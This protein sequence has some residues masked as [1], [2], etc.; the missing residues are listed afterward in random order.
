MKQRQTQELVRV[1]MD[2]QQ[3]DGSFL[4]YSV[5][6]G[7]RFGSE[8]KAYTTTFTQALIVGALAKI[9]DRPLEQ[10]RKRAA[11]FLLAQR[12]PEW[13]FNYW[14]REAPETKSRPYPDDWDD[15]SSA[16]VALTLARP[17][18]VTGEV[19][20][21][22]V[23]LLT[24][25]E[26]AEG[27]PYRTWIVPPNA[28]EH[29]QDV[30]IA[31]NSNIAYMLQLHGVD[32]PNLEHLADTCIAE[33]R[34]SSP[35][36][37]S[38]YPI[39]YFLSRWYRGAYRGQLQERI[40][41]RQ[42]TG[43]WGNPLDTALAV[44]ALLNIGA[45]PAAV[46]GAVD[47]L[48]AQRPDD[49]APY[50]FCL[51][52]AIEGRPYVAGSRALTAAFCLEAI[53]KYDE[54]ARAD[55]AKTPAKAAKASGALDDRIHEQVV[56]QAMARFDQSER[57]IQSAARQMHDRLLGGTAASQIALLPYLFRQA[58][59]ENGRSI[60]DERVVALGV[61]S[62]YGWLAYTVYDDFLDEE[63]EPPLL[64]LANIALR[65]LVLALHREAAD[66]RGFGAVAWPALDR[67]EAA[68]AWE[69]TH[70][71]VRRQSDLVRVPPPEYAD[72][73]VLAERSMGHALGCLAITMELGHGM[74]SLE[75]RA[76]QA[77]FHHFLIARQL[78]DD[79]QD[80]K[81]DLQKGQINAVGAYLL[82]GMS[83]RG[84]SVRHLYAQLDQFFWEHAVGEI[85]EWIFGE[86]TQARAA[87]KGA[88]FIQKP[89]VLEALLAPLEEA[90]HKAQAQQQQMVEFLRT[91]Q[92]EK[93]A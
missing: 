39:E 70:C 41:A 14:A 30:D 7:T 58:L 43:R 88:A 89:E 31:V 24:N 79:A 23:A 10:V 37:P 15:T 22:I 32:L 12:G 44:S 84:P 69:V 90:A 25:T 51:D 77:F 87:L 64:P 3:A 91:Y 16:I 78:C 33:G 63:G 26:T 5:P 92:P 45:E 17:K 42:K 59:G 54:A 11:D 80:W 68:N 27:G 72:R 49:I 65:E 61:I 1:L 75:V 93:P 66:T 9:P 47:W 20:G 38:P 85:N 6:L 56:A 2:D 4:S 29:W 50:A 67:Q 55:S 21:H 46:A 74:D 48:R 82:S 35:Y 34:L 19:L 8:A 76:V 36:Y 73:R 86:L 52:P 57:A 18:V 28:P 71:R 40:V 81:A 53:A 83:K 62:F 60:S 13:S